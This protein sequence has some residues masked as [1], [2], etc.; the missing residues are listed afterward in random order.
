[1]YGSKKPINMKDDLDRNREDT[2]TRDVFATHN[3]CNKKIEKLVEEEKELLGPPKQDKSFGVRWTQ[4]F[5]M[6]RRLCLLLQKDTL[7]RLPTQN[8]LH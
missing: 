1:M 2:L 8:Q 4:T 6:S 5:V 3:L 7:V